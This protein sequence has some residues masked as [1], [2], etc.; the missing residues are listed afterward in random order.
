MTHEMSSQGTASEGIDEVANS[1]G[2]ARTSSDRVTLNDLLSTPNL[3][4]EWQRVLSRL[5]VTRFNDL[6]LIR[7]PLE[8]AA[9]EWDWPNIRDLLATSVYQGRYRA[10][11]AD[12]VKAGKSK[13]LSRLMSHL[14]IEDAVIYRALID[15]TRESLKARSFAWIHANGRDEMDASA[16]LDVG[17]ESSYGSVSAGWWAQWKAKQH[18]VTRILDECSLIVET[19]ISNCF[20]SVR[21]DVLMNRLAVSS[22]LDHSL[23]NLL[24]YLINGVAPTQRVRDGVVAGLPV[25]IHDCSRALANF[26]LS[27]VDD[28][29]SAEATAGLYGRLVDDVYFGAEDAAEAQFKLGRFQEALEGIGLY[30][31]ASKTRWFTPEEFDAEYL[32]VENDEIGI[33]EDD[34]ENG[35]KEAAKTAMDRFIPRLLA[36]DRQRRG[37]DRVLRRTATQA[38]RTRSTVLLNSVPELLWERP[39]AARHLLEYRTSFA[40]SQA[41]AVALVE[42]YKI[43]HGTYEDIDALVFELFATAP[44][45][46]DAHESVLDLAHTTLKQEYSQRP[47][48]AA[49]ASIVLSKGLAD[50]ELTALNDWALRVLSSGEDTIAF[51]TLAS[52]LV[53]RLKQPDVAVVAR[54]RSSEMARLLDFLDA[55]PGDENAQEI[56]LRSVQL[57]QKKE[58]SRVQARPRSLLLIPHLIGL[59]NNAW[60]TASALQQRRYAPQRTDFKD[61]WLE[62]RWGW[63]ID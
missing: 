39:V 18:A 41:D 31:N 6:V 51:R 37:W 42:A 36:G 57:T 58:P 16:D 33:V 13:G 25:E 12:L 28:E 2:D 56:A 4:T 11:P 35:D 32:S 10:R 34:I 46:S 23:L 43:H 9:A 47:V 22:T 15:A 30:P 5:R 62:Q 26:L 55:I 59:G 14:C 49:A 8:W 40:V 29:F 50:T 53:G 61:L 60:R 3:D 54:R 21:T 27:A 19:D 44:I 7:D 1:P 24:A 52:V 17:M 38:R 48:V 45:D 63:A 20:P